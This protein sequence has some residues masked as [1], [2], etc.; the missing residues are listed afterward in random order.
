MKLSVLDLP[1]LTIDNSM[2][3]VLNRKCK[4]LSIF[5]EFIKP[6]YNYLIIKWFGRYKTNIPYHLLVSKVPDC[7]Q[8]LEKY[9]LKA[10]A[11]TMTEL[12]DTCVNSAYFWIA[13]KK[14]LKEKKGLC[15][16]SLYE[17]IHQALYAAQSFSTNDILYFKQP[18]ELWAQ[19][20][21]FR[22]GF[23]H[24]ECYN[25]EYGETRTFAIIGIIIGK[26]SLKVK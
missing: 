14:E 11:I 9:E 5:D 12:K 4:T 7:T 10:P 8:E 2:D 19:D 6:Q 16:Y 24:K 3:C 23:G 25:H 20:S 17:E 1:K 15:C 13:T 21:A 18:C 22:R 26:G